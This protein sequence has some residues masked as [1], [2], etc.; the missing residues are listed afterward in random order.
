ATLPGRA[1]GGSVDPE[2]VGMDELCRLQ[3]LQYYVLQWRGGKIVFK[4]ATVDIDLASARRHANPRDR[5]FSATGG[6]NFFGSC[7]GKSLGQGNVTN[8]GRCA[9]GKWESAR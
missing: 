7:H 1:A 3:R 9:A 4:A 5:C 2:I 8:I 6:D